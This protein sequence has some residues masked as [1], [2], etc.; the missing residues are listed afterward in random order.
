MSVRL[1]EALREA[2]ADVPAYPVHDRAVRT[3]R[4][5]RRRMA[6][7]VAAVL[8]LVALVPLVGRGGGPGPGPAP[9]GADGPA[10]PDRIGL[11]VFGALH[12][13]DRPRLGRA[14]VIFSGQARGLTGLLDENGT[15]GIVGADTDRYRTYEVGYEAPVGESVLLSPDGRRIAVPG[16]SSGH[17]RVDL[18]DLVDG[19]VRH[20]P[21]VVPGS[22]L[23]EPAGWAPDGTSLVVRDTVPANPEGGAHLN[24]LSLVRLDSGRAVRLLEAE[25][26]P[27]FGSPVAFSPDG[28]RLAWRIGDKVLIAGTDGQR[29]S[30][31]PLSPDTGLAGKGAWLPD[32]SLALVGRDPGTDRWR[33]RR[34]DPATGRD[35]GALELPA[36][37]GV[38]TIRLLGW[39]PDGSALV[40]A[41][42]PEPAAPARFDEPM[43]MDQRTTYGLVRSVAVLALVPGAAAPTTVLTAPEQVLAIDVADNVV[44]SGR[45]RDADPPWGVGGRFWW[46]AGSVALLLLGGLLARRVV[47]RARGVRG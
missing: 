4:R 11:P 25:Q 38:T 2:A 26:L 28:S 18:V 10:L 3:A 17:P 1:R 21:S 35:L 47:T 15:I 41:Y 13:T 33:L 40:V 27:I 5:T 23:T 19:V 43:E 42:R 6:A 32:G 37:T 29:I 46:W 30:S 36:V 31:F 34:A 14:S 22:A 9:A 7:G 44:H 39:R 12:A 20:L 8:L 45:I 24:V 16:G